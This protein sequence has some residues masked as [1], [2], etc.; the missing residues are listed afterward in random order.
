MQ[1]KKDFVIPGAI[2]PGPNKPGDLESF[3]LPSL[4]HVAALQHEGLQIHNSY[5]NT[6]IPHSIPCVLF[7]TA[8]S[9]GSAS[10]SGMVGHIGR[11]GC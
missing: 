3:L 1:Y 5:T 8:D 9:L 6:L 10:M 7:G 2:V 4:Y 11:Y